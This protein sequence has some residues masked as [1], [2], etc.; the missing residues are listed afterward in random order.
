MRSPLPP[1]PGPAEPSL[2]WSGAAAQWDH[3]VDDGHCEQPGI[4][5]R[6]MTQAQ[7][8]LLLE[9]TVRVMGDAP[10]EVKQRHIPNCAKADQAYGAAVARALGLEPVDIAAE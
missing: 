1:S 2:D 8:Q 5:F 9:N 3:R 10:L 7:Q 4:I 6:K